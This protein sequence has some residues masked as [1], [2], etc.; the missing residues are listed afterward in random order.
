MLSGIDISNISK[1]Y[2]IANTRQKSKLLL[3]QG[4]A[5]GEFIYVTLLDT[6]TP[7]CT[8]RPLTP[9]VLHLQTT[10]QMNTM[11][12]MTTANANNPPITA[13]AIVPT[14]LLQ[15]TKTQPRVMDNSRI[16]HQMFQSTCTCIYISQI[17]VHILIQQKQ[18][19]PAPRVR[20]Q[21]KSPLYGLSNRRKRHHL[22]FILGIDIFGV[23][24]N[25]A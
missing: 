3:L 10:T 19:K 24:V 22:F 4:G 18:T 17:S 15:Q 7:G 6:P 2:N 11:I 23:R 8:T 20:L 14:E 12:P 21:T 25:S 9:V 5:D 1:K 13:P 16:Q